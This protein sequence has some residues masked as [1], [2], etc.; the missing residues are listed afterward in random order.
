MRFTSRALAASLLSASASALGAQVGSTTWDSVAAI[1]RTPTTVTDGY[2][3]YNLPRRDITLRI[4]DLAVSPSLGLGTWAG[5][6]G[7]P[8]DATMMATSSSSAAN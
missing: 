4:G 3:R 8:E 7:T 6:G 5:F 1:L 2:R